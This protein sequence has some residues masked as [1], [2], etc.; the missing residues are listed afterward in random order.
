MNIMDR[1][2]N[3]EFP[4]RRR[5][6]L[7]LAS[8]L[9]LGAVF[10]ALVLLLGSC[11][12]RFD[13]SIAADG[14]ARIDFKAEVPAVVGD[15]LRK[16]GAAG[17][18]T[19][20]AETPL[21]DLGQVRSAIVAR[22]ELSLVELSR[23]SPDSLKGTV[24]VKSLAKLASGPGLAG[25]GALAYS[26]GPG[27]AELRIRLARGPESG[28]AALLPGVDPYLLDALSPPALEE[29]GAGAEEY[30]TMLRSVFGEKAMPALE[31]AAAT[32]ALTVPGEPIASGGGVLEG[33][34]LKVRLPMVDVLVLEKPIEF[35]IRWKR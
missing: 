1:L 6:L 8:A 23:P 9:C 35:W 10:L 31:A 11:A 18:G 14:G 5:A 30:R 2:R 34:S 24:A 7:V 29:E 32:V 20:G 25:T 15:K 12:A 16:L 17:G 4:L 21:F 3:D 13:G 22:P 28:L 26:T 33:R 27:W 19:V